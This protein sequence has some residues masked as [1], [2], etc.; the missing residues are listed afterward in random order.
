MPPYEH[1]AGRYLFIWKRLIKG[2]CIIYCTYLLSSIK[3]V[4]NL[5]GCEVYYQYLIEVQ[6]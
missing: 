4:R 6:L 3:H 2:H 1:F 5:F